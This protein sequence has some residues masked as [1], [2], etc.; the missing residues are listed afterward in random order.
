M[1]KNLLT[2]IGVGVVLATSC[3]L[4]QGCQGGL[5]P[6]SYEEKCCDVSSQLDQKKRTGNYDSPVIVPLFKMGAGNGK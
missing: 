3:I 2:K 1:V 4:S 6:T 5:K